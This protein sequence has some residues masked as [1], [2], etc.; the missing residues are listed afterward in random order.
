VAARLDTFLADRQVSEEKRGQSMR[1]IIGH[2][3]DAIAGMH[4]QLRG[5]AGRRETLDA[6]LDA[7]IADFNEAVKGL[8]AQCDQPDADLTRLAAD[9]KDQLQR[10]E[11]ICQ[12]WE[13]EAGQDREQIQGKQAEFRRRTDESFAKSFFMHRARTWPRGYP[14]DFEIIDRAYDNQP[15]STGLGYLFDL[16]FLSTTLAHGIRYRRALMREILADTMRERH[17]SRILNIGCGPCREIMELAP[18]ILET[19]ARFVCLDHDQAA[20]DYSAARLAECGLETHVELRHYNALRMVNA[21]RTIREFGSFDIIYTIGLLDY[22][23]DDVL[24]RLI[25]ALHLVLRPGGE[26]IAVFKDCDRY[27]TTDYHWL[28]N[29]TGFLQRTRQDSWRLIEAAGIPRD[30]VTIQRSQDDV[31]IFYRVL[32]RTA[33][34]EHA[35]PNLPRDR[36]DQVI[37]PIAHPSG[38]AG[39][40]RRETPSERRKR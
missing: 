32:R 19:H 28:V 22:L 35:S 4:V 24:V 6:Q 13:Y 3:H 27:D 18:L 1:K 17:G 7:A 12:A 20:L 25:Q 5:V 8:E 9:L 26:L 21:E 16:Y 2:I 11:A 36:R 39:R 31:M 38:R 29:W 33:V 40:S 30:A 15:L 10:V 14:G 34:A 37:E 23:S